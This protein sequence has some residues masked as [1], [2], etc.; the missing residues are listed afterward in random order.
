M[1]QSPWEHNWFCSWSRNSPHFMEP[2]SSSPFSQAP[3]TCPYPEPTPSSPHNPFTPPGDPSFYYPPIYVWSPQC[4]LSLSFPHQNLVQTSPFIH[5]CHIPA[6]LIL[7]FINRTILGE[8]YRSLSSS[9]C[10]F[11]H[12]CYPIPLGPKYCPQHPVLK[13]PQPMF[14]RQCQRRRFTSIQNNGQN[15]SSDLEL[16]IFGYQTKA[17]G[18]APSG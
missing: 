17:K 6:L 16:L 18:P 12:S 9:L 13:H 4:S 15:Y 3:V 5:T 14:L 10:N 7:D 1:E 11:L 2:E 8:E